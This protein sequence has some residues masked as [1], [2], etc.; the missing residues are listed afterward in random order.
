MRCTGLIRFFKTFFLSKIIFFVG[1]L[2][3][4]GEKNTRR[5]GWIMLDFSSIFSKMQ[6]HLW[7]EARRITSELGDQECMQRNRNRDKGRRKTQAI[8]TGSFHKPEVVLC[9]LHFQREFTKCNI[10]LQMLKHTSKKLLSNKIT[11]K[12]VEIEQLIYNQWC[13]QNKSD[14]DS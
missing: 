4:E 9:P 3:R 6:E 13:S 14:T 10:W 5:G 7:S 11:R 2:N 8:Y 1:V 12:M